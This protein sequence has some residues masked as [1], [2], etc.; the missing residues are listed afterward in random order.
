M[1]LNANQQKAVEA[2]GHCLVTACPGSGK[3]RVLAHR[4]A[5]LLSMGQGR[6]L[7]VTFTK[8]AASSLKTRILEASGQSAGDRLAV[9]TLHSLALNQLKRAGQMKTL[10][11]PSETRL[12]IR[13]AVNEC[14]DKISVD[15]A[16]AA[17]DAFKSTMEQPLPGY[18]PENEVYRLYRT[19]MEQAGLIDF[20]DLLMLAVLGMRD[21]SIKPYQADWLLVDEAQ[22][23]DGVQMEWVDLHRQAGLETMLVADDD[24]SIYG[25]RNA[26]GHRGL[27]GFKNKS[28]AE[29]ITLPVNY[30]C[31]QQIIQA[32]AKLIDFNRERVAKNVVGASANQGKVRIFQVEDRDHEANEI[33]GLLS[34]SQ[35]NLGEFAI[36]ARTNLLLDNTEVALIAH[37]IP[38]Y[39]N[40][41]KSLWEREVPT[42]M[43]G[44]F[45]ALTDKRHSGLLIALHFAGVK[46]NVIEAML[47]NEGI[48]IAKP[49]DTLHQ[50]LLD[51][52]KQ[53]GKFGTVDRDRLVD[54]GNLLT[55]W[56]QLLEQKK[57]SLVIAGVT[58]WIRSYLPPEHM[59]HDIAE[60]LAKSL[61]E[62]KGTLKERV[63]YLTQQKPKKSSDN[64]VALMTLHSS[65]GL[66]WDRVWMV[67]LEQD[68]LPHPDSPLEEER[69]LCYVGMTRARHELYISYMQAAGAS[70]FIEQ[71]G[72]VT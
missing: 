70:V 23:L 72:F 4:A 57:L 38:Y 71:S 24:Q 13:R 36:L 28:K 51:P 6:L 25:W 49:Y 16:T 40:G 37:G 60:L 54:F 48:D 17:I 67:A 8:D 35:E 3:T 68:V 14:P 65:K 2:T 7:A 27:I 15:D 1:S 33:L 45:R 30:R 46:A 10:A 29:L 66:E 9:G 56:R 63:H 59:D 50:A 64:A 69:R 34:Q 47:P 39:R 19:Y 52:P 11:S 31:D 44:I 42:V 18:S 62:M 12:L 20:S 22:D 58:R 53:A 32:A 26:M 43:V 21:G 61:N 55:N 41:G 5:R